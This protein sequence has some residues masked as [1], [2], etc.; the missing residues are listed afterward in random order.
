VDVREASLEVMRRFGMTTIF[1]NP[2][3]T[4]VAFLTDL[5]ADI[6]FV[7]A[8]HE[9]SV[10]GLATGYA[11]ARSRTAFVN[12]HTA[13]GLGNAVNAI[14]NARDC[15]APLVVVVG[16]QA[17]RQ[18]A[19]EPFLAGRALERLAGEYPVWS[20]LPVRAQ[21]VPGAIARAHHEAMTRRGPALV[22][23]PMDDWLQEADPLAAAAP[24]SVM[25]PQPAP[26]Q[27]IS[28]LAQ[29]LD[30]AHSPAI[31][32]GAG[33]ATDAG[34]RAV[35]ELAEALQSPVWQEAFA[36]RAGFPQDHPLFAGHLPWP[37]RG[38]RERLAPHD[39]VLVLGTYAFR[40]Y[41]FDEELALVA[42]DTRVA[43]ISEDP[44]EVHRSPC[45]LGFVAGVAPAC[46][47]LAA[48]VSRR[49][50]P[51][52]PEPVD[53]PSLPPPPPPAPGTPLAP[54]H[55]LTALAE[56]LPA[57]AVVVEETPSS[58]SELQQR[59]PARS[60]L[61]FVSNGNGGLGFGIPGAIGLRMALP[62]RPVVGVIGDGSAMYAIQSLWSSAHYRVG[63]LVIVMSNGGYAIMDAQA[64]ERGGSGAWPGFGAID[65]AGMAQCLGCPSAK[66]TEYAGLIAALDQVVPGLAQRQ[67][68]LLLEV[69]VRP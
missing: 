60:P 44:A 11:I 43:V 37:R 17:R 56:R 57:D 22:V 8:L 13:A 34:W 20:T 23:V 47:A 58:R 12:L 39:A 15:R 49:D 55:V 35:V 4:E 16:Q 2:G 52:A 1:G 69:A 38:I 65:I 14:A 63:V 32:V 5:P 40:T 30:G 18:L 61:G 19:H 62:T 28:E 33:A 29:L 45:H 9:G 50:A 46:S 53:P 36:S 6:D 41:L 42:P 24:A 51:R 48:R 31:V 64:R 3:S 68:P 54:G 66:V 7:L 67:E 26:G 25:R 27:E 59:I 10:V 21:D